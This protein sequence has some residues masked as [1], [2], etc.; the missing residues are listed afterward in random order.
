MASKGMDGPN[1][2]QYANLREEELV[3]LAQQGDR[4][5]EQ[6]LIFSP[7]GKKSSLFDQVVR[8]SHQKLADRPNIAD[9]VVQDI[10]EQV[11]KGL[12]KFRG[13]NDKNEPVKFGTWVLGI[14]NN[15]INKTL[16]EISSEIDYR[17]LEKLLLNITTLNCDEKTKTKAESIVSEIQ[18]WKQSR[19]RIDANL[20]INSIS[21]LA[22][23][24][25]DLKQKRHLREFI[26][27]LEEKEA[28]PFV[29]I[30]Q[31]YSLNQEEK[32]VAL[33]F[34]IFETIASPKR[35][36]EEEFIFKRSIE[37]IEKIIKDNFKYPD[38]A[39]MIVVL[40]IEG[41]TLQEISDTLGMSGPPRVLEYKTR[42]N[43]L[44]SKE[45]I[46]IK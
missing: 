27:E 4:K 39:I 31:S 29:Q 34:D 11:C 18:E 41:Y 30:E 21:E 6:F 37:A 5:A 8:Y 17:R 1:K 26:I 44:I 7:L 46:G 33:D 43:A 35:G 3:Q 42:L 24:V 45:L 40:T 22:S 19:K 14:R 25:D 2:D 38:K 10:L 13:K 16:K 9:Q 28:R 15:V 20:L 23:A 32:N 36:P 12:N